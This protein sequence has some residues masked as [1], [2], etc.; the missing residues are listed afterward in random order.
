MKTFLRENTWASSGVNKG[1]GNGYVALPRRHPYFGLGYDEIN[2]KLEHYVHGG[3][4][5]SKSSDDIQDW[6]QVAGMSDMWIIGWDTA[7][8]RDTI[9]EWPRERVLKENQILSVYLVKAWNDDIKIQSNE[10]ELFMN[11]LQNN[12]K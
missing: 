7:H 1:W 5:F 10:V 2:E 3:L 6:E 11:E 9:E 8:W 12:L 4:T